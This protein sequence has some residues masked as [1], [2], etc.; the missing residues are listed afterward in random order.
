MAVI[1]IAIKGIPYYRLPLGDRNHHVMYELWKPSGLI[2]HGL[3]MIGGFLLILLLGYVLRKRLRFMHN[4]GNIRVWLNYHIWMGITGPL[5]IVFHTSFKFG[6][7]VVVSFWSMV[8]VAMSGILGRYIYTQIP[9]TYMGE[10]IGLEELNEQE[11]S[12]WSKLQKLSGVDTE[13]INQIKPH[14]D[15]EINVLQKSSWGVLPSLLMSDLIRLLKRQRLRRILV[16]KTELNPGQIKQVLS[17]TDQHER[18]ARRIN[19]LDA[20]QKMLHQWHI[21]HRPFAAL[22]FLIM[23][24]HIGIAVLFGYTWIF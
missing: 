23:I 3:G 6:G 15:H 11:H 24:A 17:I 19:T 10:E 7:I 9:H 22:M 14:L 1:G 4:W 8:A 13:I 18:I 2:G 16:S 21:I 12:Y 5:I 20:A